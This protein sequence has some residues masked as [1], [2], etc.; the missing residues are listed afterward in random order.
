[1][2]RARQRAAITLLA[3]SSAIAL[4]APPTAVINGPQQA[5][6]GD[7][8]VLDASG[9]HAQ[10]FAWVLADSDK[11]FLPVDDGKRMVFATASAGRYTFVLVTGQTNETGQ[12]AIAIARHT[13]TIGD[14]PSPP[15]P[16]APDPLPPGRFNLATQARNWTQSLS[17]SSAARRRTAQLVAAVFDDVATAI[18]AG[19]VSSIPDALNKLVQANQAALTPEEFS[20]WKTTWNPSLQAAMTRLDEAGQLSALGDVA[21]AFREI[22]LGLKAS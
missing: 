13:I 9:S 5:L 10:G 11:S 2:A 16:P 21:D 20:A 15:T 4:A 7:L 3:L 14:G 12:P 1:M 8:V 18:K 17:L 22:A 19:T 6:P